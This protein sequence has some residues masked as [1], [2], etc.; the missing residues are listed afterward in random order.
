MLRVTTIAS[1]H[2]HETPC[3]SVA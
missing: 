2:V 3:E 1:H